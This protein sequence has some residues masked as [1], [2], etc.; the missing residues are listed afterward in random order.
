MWPERGCHQ[1]APLGWPLIVAQMNN[2]KC[3]HPAPPDL[4]P[5]NELG[6]DGEPG[7]SVDFAADTTGEAADGPDFYRQLDMQH[8]AWGISSS[9]GQALGQQSQRE[10]QFPPTAP[11]VAAPRRRKKARPQRMETHTDAVGMSASLE[12]AG[13]RSPQQAASEEPSRKR[14]TPHARRAARTPATGSAL[15][16]ALLEAQQRERSNSATGQQA[17]RRRK[18]QQAER[19]AAKVAE[20]QRMASMDVVLALTRHTDEADQ[21]ADSARAFLGLARLD[22]Q[23]VPEVLPSAGSSQL[24][25]TLATV[26]RNDGF[27]SLVN[28]VYAQ[29]SSSVSKEILHD[30]FELQQAG[31]VTVCMESGSAAISAVVVLTRL[32]FEDTAR[33]DVAASTAATAASVTETDAM[34]LWVRKRRGLAAAVKRLMQWARPD[35][36][37]PQ[38]EGDSTSKEEEDAKEEELYCDNMQ[39]Q[40][41]EPVPSST[42]KMIADRTPGE[43]QDGR[44]RK[45]RFDSRTLYQELF[46]THKAGAGKSWEPRPDHRLL[47]STLRHYQRAA[48]EWMI[49]RETAKD[50]PEAGARRPHPLWERVEV[51]SGAPP[52]SAVSKSA[53]PFFYSISEGTLLRECPMVGPIDGVPDIPGGILADEMGLGKSLELLYCVLHHPKPTALPVPATVSPDDIDAAAT[54]ATAEPQCLTFAVQCDQTERPLSFGDWY[55][56]SGSEEDL[57]SQAF[58]DTVTP[59]CRAGWVMVKSKEDLGADLPLY[60]DTDTVTVVSGGD[61]SKMPLKTVLLLLHEALVNLRDAS[62][63]LQSEAFMELPAR[64]S[65]PGYYKLIEAPVCLDMI[66]ER[67][68]A[69]Q[70]GTV[71]QFQDDVELM[72]HNAQQYNAEGSQVFVD[73]EAL[74][75]ALGHLCRRCSRCGCVSPPGRAYSSTVRD[76]T[77][78]CAAHWHELTPADRSDYQL[79][80]R[81]DGK[82][83]QLECCSCKETRSVA[84]STLPDFGKDQEAL[85]YYCESCESELFRPL[86]TNDGELIDSGATLIVC[87]SAICQQW[88]SE[89]SKHVVEKF[90]VHVYNG[91]RSGERTSAKKLAAQ[92]I[93][94]TTYDVLRQDVYHSAAYQAGG[95]GRSSRFRKKHRTVPTP[96]TALRWWRVCLDEAQ[97]VETT[98]AKAAEMA[99]QLPTVHRWCVTGTPIARGLED[100]YGLLVF[101]QAAPLADRWTWLNAIKKPCELIVPAAVDQFFRF[102]CKIMWRS[103]RTDV[104]DQIALPRQHEHTELLQFS[105]IE[106]YYYERQHSE[107]LA[108][109]KT[110]L[111]RY[112]GEPGSTVVTHHS[113][114]TPFLRLRQA[115]CHHQIGQA[116]K[117][118]LNSKGA[119]AQRPLTMSELTEKLLSKANTEAE[120]AQRLLL[121]SM[122]GLAAITLL[123]DGEDEAVKHQ[124]A[125]RIYELVLQKA[126]EHVEQYNIK[127]DDLQRIHALTNLS[128]LVREADTERAYSL[129]EQA[130]ELRKN[131][132]KLEHQDF[133]VAKVL[134]FQADEKLRHNGNQ[135]LS[136]HPK[137]HFD[138]SGEPWWARAASALSELDAADEFIR[139]LKGELAELAGSAKGGR[140]TS[141]ALQFRDTRG[142]VYGLRSQLQ[143]MWRS[144]CEM[145]QRIEALSEMVSDDDARAAGNCKNCRPWGRGAVCT[146]CVVERDVIIGYE[147]RLFALIRDK[148][149]ARSHT[150]DRDKRAHTAAA[151]TSVD[152]R[153]AWNMKE[154]SRK[155]TALHV[156]RSP[157]EPELALAA[158]LRFVSTVQ[159]PHGELNN[160]VEEGKDHIQAIGL[161]KKEF[162]QLRDLWLAQREVLYRTDELLMSEMR[163]KMCAEGEQVEQDEQHFKLQSQHEV[164]AKKAEFLSDRIQHEQAFGDANA[165]FT[166]L[167]NLKIQQR[168]ASADGGGEPCPVCHEPMKNGSD[169]MI[170]PCGHSFCYFC[171]MRLYERHHAENT[172][173]PICKRMVA[174]K[175]LYHVRERNGAAMGASAAAMARSGGHSAAQASADTGGSRAAAATIAPVVDAAAVVVAAAAPEQESSDGSVAIATKGD[176]GSKLDRLTMLLLR[177]AQ[178]D[179]SAKTIVFSQW[180]SVLQIASVAFFANE[181][182]FSDAFSKGGRQQDCA[183]QTF[184]SSSEVNVLLLATKSGANGLN[185][186]E[187]VNVV[188]VE[189]VLSPAVEA[190][191]VSRVLRIG[192]TKETHVYRLIVQGVSFSSWPPAPAAAAAARAAA[193]PA[194]RLPKHP[195]DLRRCRYN[196]RKDHGSAEAAARC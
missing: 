18:M 139:R 19:A 16:N 6:L 153:L 33:A 82:H 95:Q 148:Q 119:T 63:R 117:S 157:A 5:M 171:I 100:L 124:A 26:C 55:H 53:A 45:R 126:Q 24:R 118:F 108:A 102:F 74:Q 47:R 121:A 196:R 99:Q 104:A 146:H 143:L 127:T 128:L 123:E 78:L 25:A 52:M 43:S 106:A 42:I 186:T 32:A 12:P 110:A 81:D 137:R 23:S 105:D 31:W 185:L 60:L 145:K 41:Q 65:Y 134:V 169:I 75:E 34:K 181:I 73:A 170:T 133:Q 125:I 85:E 96:L 190:Q 90:R 88:M 156:S 22:L 87:P 64:R 116:S 92:H 160:L 194:L 191:A 114:A 58:V 72:I 94:I 183:I 36:F 28:T 161:M 57:S 184:K 79:D 15:A 2:A 9:R 67:I 122:N 62:L 159:D 155:Q 84:L 167:R 138:P 49:S 30:L 112:H 11:T 111:Q 80:L 39:T 141:A 120:E 27:P 162:D 135:A 187:A 168:L 129:R 69:G 35:Q 195:R 68:V 37:A 83:I 103:A 107:C 144:R 21:E 29:V 158:L 86:Q 152:P 10:A 61:A 51:F 91:L 172:S 163:I 8:N 166:Y 130:L 180:S 70:Y 76:S 38:R 40:Q 3:L 182:K 150:N 154:F 98:T 89:I 4:E 149:N 113:W 193:L 174:K 147:Q 177:I 17:S 66:R 20:S 44:P 176:F 77:C 132:S 179:P 14:R 97:M 50:T 115:C 188:L 1:L 71:V 189:P 56:H 165:R 109:A 164:V 178:Q 140:G 175:E 151:T 13:R 54:A 59:A 192:Q 136:G 173:C 131:Y 142:L 93:V 7:P 101:L 46:A 48:A